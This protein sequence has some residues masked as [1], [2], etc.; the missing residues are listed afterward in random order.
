M[1][2][3]HYEWFG[4]RTKSAGICA[5]HI[6][7]GAARIEHRCREIFESVKRWDYATIEIMVEEIG[8]RLD[9]D[10]STLKKLAAAFCDRHRQIAFMARVHTL[11]T[12]K[13]RSHQ[14][15]MTS[16]CPGCDPNYWK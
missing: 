11:L 2:Q 13:R 7:P 12:K 4:E 1:V 15:V 3:R 10:I 5:Q 8:E 6:K 14:L 9:K 16:K